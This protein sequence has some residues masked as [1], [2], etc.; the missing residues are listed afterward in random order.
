MPPQGILKLPVAPLGLLASEHLGVAKLLRSQAQIPHHGHQVEADL[1][2][3]VPRDAALEDFHDLFRKRL[4]WAAASHS[5]VGDGRGLEA[6]ELVQG[7][8]DVCVGDEVEDVLALARVLALR[9][10]GERARLGEAI[11]HVTNQL[12]VAECL[13]AELGGQ[14]HGEFLEVAEVGA[15]VDLAGLVLVEQHGQQSLRAARILDRLCGEEEVLCRVVVEC[16]VERL[17]CG[18]IGAVCRILEE[19]D[20]AVDWMELRESLGLK[21]QQLLELHILDTKAV[22]KICEDA[23]I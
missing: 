18:G 10:I 8:V 9:L 21:R 12:R 23:S 4:L 6:V 7:A 15:N 14:N 2:H 5:A 19:E 16:A 1:R 17:V 11:V 20:D 13:A 22:K 3:V